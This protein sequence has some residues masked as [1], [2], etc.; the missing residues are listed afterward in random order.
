MGH[1]DVVPLV[2]RGINIYLPII[3]V[4]LCLATWFRLGTRFLHSIGVD[5]FIDDDNMTAELI[6]SGRAIVSLGKFNYTVFRNFLFRTQQNQSS[7]KQRATAR[8]VGQQIE[9]CG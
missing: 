1:L 4:L 3:I 6:Q 8:N 2:A 9:Q 5:Q 7:A